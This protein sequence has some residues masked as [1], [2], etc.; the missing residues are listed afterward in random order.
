MQIL[1]DYDKFGESDKL[2]SFDVSSL[3]TRVPVE[4][5][6]KIVEE[7]LVELRS[8]PN[9][10]VSQIMSLSTSAILK[11]LRLAVTQCYF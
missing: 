6:L 10:P 8:L 11:L 7:C 3:Y 1:V 9:D 2:I 4:D 5:S